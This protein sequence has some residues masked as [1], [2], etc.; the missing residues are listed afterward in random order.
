MDNSL[1]KWQLTMLSL[2]KEDFD[3]QGLNPFMVRH[4]RVWSR[5]SAVQ[6]APGSSAAVQCLNSKH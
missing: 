4:A 2:A 6:L 1:H 3:G 5:A